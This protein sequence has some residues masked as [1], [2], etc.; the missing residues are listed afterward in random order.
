MQISVKSAVAAAVL[1]L[2]AGQALAIDQGDIP[3][4]PP[5]IPAGG[6]AINAST[7][8]SGPVLVA[9]WDINTGSSLVQWLGLSY[10][11]V[12][13]TEMGGATLNFGTL[14]GYS[15]TFADAITNN[16]TSRLQWMVIGADTAADQ[17]FGIGD[18]F[19][20]GLRITGQPNLTEIADA[21]QVANAGNQYIKYI[22]DVINNNIAGPPTACQQ[23]NPCS[24]VGNPASPIYWGRAEL[25]GNLGGNVP[26]TTSYAGN[27]GSALAFF[28]VLSATAE[29]FLNNGDVGA[30]VA[31]YANAQWLLDS[32]GHL[33]FNA[34][35]AP[36][37][38]PAAAWLLLS[39][40]AGL[41]VVGRRKS[42]PA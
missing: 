38:L 21:N 33:T 2:S 24:I 23:A 39:G 10:D 3:S 22:T 11:Q 30:T 28:E 12:S 18:P 15:T 1:A 19:D 35:S 13:Q 26:S 29:D 42:T 4:Q 14:S 16:Q 36:V 20:R 7:T 25:S 6:L 17:T 8:G 27:V 34:A 32:S 40:L 5:A 31:Q 41:G 9:V 37:P